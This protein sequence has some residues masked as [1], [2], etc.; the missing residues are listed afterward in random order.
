VGLFTAVPAGHGDGAGLPVCMV[1]HGASATTADFRAFGL[2]RFLT[3]A[4]QAGAA[5][6]VLAGLDG[7]AIRWSR[8]GNDDP[9]RMLAD[10]LPGWLRERGFGPLEAAWGW[11]MGG[12]GVLSYAATYPGTLRAAAAFSPAIYPSDPLAARLTRPGALGTTQLGVWC[13]TDDPLQPG[14]ASVVSGMAMPPR[15]TDYSPGAHTRAYWDDHT[16]AAFAFL[17]A[18]VSRQ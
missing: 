3:A 13:G 8:N 7:G 16:L 11:S 12:F 18:M 9:Q 14:I 2:P 10:E 4:V 1:L 17:S 5:P 6:F 15:I